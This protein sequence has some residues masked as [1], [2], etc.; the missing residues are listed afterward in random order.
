MGVRRVAF[1]TTKKMMI[2]INDDCDKVVP[3]W[4]HAI[5]ITISSFRLSFF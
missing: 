1:T 4:R 3:V 5:A 2:M